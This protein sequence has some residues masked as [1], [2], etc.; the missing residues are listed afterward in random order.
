MSQQEDYSSFFGREEKPMESETELEAYREKIIAAERES[1]G[2]RALIILLNAIFFFL[3]TEMG[4]FEPEQITTHNIFAYVILGISFVYSCFTYLF[5]PYERYPVMLASYFSYVS[6]MM[7]ITL[8]LYA[9]GGFHSPFYIMWYV[10]IAVVAFRFNWRIVWATS[11][12][13]VVCYVALVLL[14]SQVHSASEIVDLSLR[15]MYI[16]AIGY[17]ASLI[18]KETFVQTTEKL[19]MKNITRSLLHT[20][21]ELEEKKEAL[22]E[23]TGLLED[24]VTERTRDLEANAKNFSLLL[25]AIHLIT[26]T[27]TPE[28]AVN[29]HNKAWDAFFKGSVDGNDL[30]A[31]VHPDD[32]AEVKRKWL[33]VKET[34]NTG[35]G[36]FRWKKHDGQWRDMQVE[37]ICLKNEEQQ[38]IM[39]IGTATDITA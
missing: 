14:L 4:Y 17:I 20:Q 39:W 30:S 36:Q 33:E 31:F 28:G 38:I 26:W 19:Q 24:K 10:A 18:S 22:E 3:L 29:Y 23:L 35:S 15:C 6:D 1:G 13:Y 34:G 5:K 16:V 37:I 11:M 25:D 9:T 12:L 32:L 21:R 8:W 7:F 27:T 2:I